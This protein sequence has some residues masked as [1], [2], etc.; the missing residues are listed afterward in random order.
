MED[1]GASTPRRAEIRVRDNRAIEKETLV[2]I[3]SSPWPQY[4]PTWDPRRERAAYKALMAEQA[5][6][7]DSVAREEARCCAVF[8]VFRHCCQSTRRPDE[9]RQRGGYKPSAGPASGLLSFRLVRPW[10][11][12][13]LSEF[14][15]QI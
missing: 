13:S 5:E 12:L 7:R 14:T 1:S 8:G 10:A 2:G 4:L 15:I 9:N 3:T 6:L 11:S